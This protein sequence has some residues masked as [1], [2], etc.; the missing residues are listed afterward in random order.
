MLE[1]NLDLDQ[2]FFQADVAPVVSL[3]VTLCFSVR[4]KPE[5]STGAPEGCDAH[6]RIEDLGA[7]LGNRSR[8][9]KMRQVP[10]A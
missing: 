3:T 10:T 6:S 8:H 7:K 2:Y 9:G 1:L 5:T 4:S